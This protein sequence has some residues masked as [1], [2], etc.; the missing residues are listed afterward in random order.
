[1]KDKDQVAIFESYREDILNKFKKSLEG[2]NEPEIENEPENMNIPSDDIS[3]SD[4][5]D[6][7]DVEE[8]PEKKKKNVIV[9]SQEVGVDLGEKLREIARRLPDEIED[10]DVLSAIKDAVKDANEDRND[11]DKINQSPLSI[12]DDLIG[13]GAYTEEEKESDEYSFGD[14]DEIS[15]AEP[16]DDDY[17]DDDDL[18]GETEFDLSKK[19]RKNREDFR[20]S[21]R[22]DVERSKVEDYLRQ[23]GVDWED[24]GLPENDY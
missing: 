18:T 24:R 14:K 16:E 7:D 8:I 21:M 4:E 2:E 12:Y 10:V 1:M 17:Y 23:M 9:R 13:S 6:M 20:S 19:T 11:D 15:V 22:K 5:S 3:D